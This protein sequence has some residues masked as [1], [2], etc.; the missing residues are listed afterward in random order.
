MADIKC[1]GYHL[2]VDVL[3]ELEKYDW[4]SHEIRNGKLIAASPF[5]EDNHPS[6]FVDLE[7][8][9]WADSGAVIEYYESGN[10]PK[11]L[12]LLSGDSYE[13]TCRYL[14]E[15]YSRNVVDDSGNVSIRTDIQ[16]A[17]KS[18]RKIL[19][20][21]L[22]VSLKKESVYLTEKRGISTGVQRY[23]DTG[24][25][26]ERN[27]ISIPWR[28]ADGKLAAIKYRNIDD[29]QFRYESGGHAV[30]DLVY[31]LDKIYEMESKEA[32]I[33]EAEIDALSWM[34]RGIPAI[35]LGGSSIS[36]KQKENIVKSPIEVLVL[37]MDNDEP[38][39]TLRSKIIESF[40]GELEL[41]EAL[42]PE[43]YKDSNEAWV[44]GVDLG[45]LDQTTLTTFSI[46]T[47]K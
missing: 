24:F 46:G 34:S 16:I 43:K 44:N 26:E 19:D 29:K 1:Q 3:E 38:G 28:H 40:K 2:D 9:G 15:R 32:I 36:D 25:S 27:S 12:A 21:T 4:I 41:R 22:N 42:I 17:E 8:G 47:S 45:G 31:G 20:E 5:R 11:L 30:S 7:T 14:V 33:C 39:G 37:A 35:A 18:A 23:M 13:D 6:F 10:F